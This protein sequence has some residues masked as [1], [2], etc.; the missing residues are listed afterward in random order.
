MPTTLTDSALLDVYRATLE[1]IVRGSSFAARKSSRW[2]VARRT[3]GRVNGPTAMT[4]WFR[5]AVYDGPQAV[6]TARTCRP[7]RLAP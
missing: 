6:E 7:P 5:G 3:A 4:G 2:S 1:K